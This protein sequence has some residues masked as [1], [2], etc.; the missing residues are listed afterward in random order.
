MG[1]SAVCAVGPRLAE[2]AAGQPGPRALLIVLP[3]LGW[4][5]RPLQEQRTSLRDGVG[6]R[7]KHLLKHFQGGGGAETGPC[8]DV[9]NSRLGHTWSATWPLAS[10]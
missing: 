4:F 3:I 9:L 5:L 8:G 10:G 7:I 1:I 2:P 6:G